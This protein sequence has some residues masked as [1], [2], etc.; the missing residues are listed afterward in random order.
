MDPLAYEDNSTTQVLADIDLFAERFSSE[1]ANSILYYHPEFPKLKYALQNLK[2]SY[3]FDAS[4]DKIE[5]WSAAYAAGLI[6]TPANQAGLLSQDPFFNGL[7]SAYLTTMLSYMNLDYRNGSFWKY[8]YLSIACLN[9]NN[10][11]CASTAPSNTYGVGANLITGRCEADKNYMWQ[12]F[13]ALYVALKDRFVNEHMANMVSGSVYSSL[14]NNNYLR[15]FGYSEEYYNQAGFMANIANTV[16]NSAGNNPGAEQGHMQQQYIEN[17]DSYI[18]FWKQ[19][20]EKCDV[21]NLHPQKEAILTDITARLKQICIEGSDENHLDGSSTVRPSSTYTPTSFEEVIRQ[22]MAFYQIP[23]SELCHPYL[24]SHPR[25]YDLQP[26]TGVDIVIDKKDECLCTKI[27]LLTLM[28]ALDPN[29]SNLNVPLSSKISFYLANKFSQTVDAALL[30]NL[31]N[32]CNGV[33]ANCETNDPPLEIPAFLSDCKPLIKKCVS[34]AEYLALK[35]RFTDNN[36]FFNGVVFNT[37]PLSEQQIRKNEAFEAFMNQA[38]GFN[39]KWQ[40]YIQFENSCI[41]GI[42]PW[43]YNGLMQVIKTFDST[44]NGSLSGAACQYAFAQVFNGRFT[45]MFNYAQIYQIYK[46]NGYTLEICNPVVTASDIKMLAKEFYAYYGANYWQN[47]NW[48]NDFAVHFNGHYSSSY[49]FADI[50]SIIKVLCGEAFSVCGQYSYPHL[51]KLDSLYKVANNGQAWLNAN[52][53]QNFT[54]YFN[55]QTQ[56]QLT[57]QDIIKKYSDQT[58]QLNVCL[59]PVECLF[60]E[61]LIDNYRNLGSGA[62]PG[63]SQQLTPEEYCKQCFASFASQELGYT[64]TYEQLALMYKKTCAKEIFDLCKQDYTCSSLSEFYNDFV[65][66]YSDSLT[67]SNCREFFVTK[68]NEK[69]T[70]QHSFSQIAAIYILYCDKEPP[71][72]EKVEITDAQQIINVKKKFLE[73]YPDPAGFFGNACAARFTDFF[74]QQFYSK[75]TYTEIENYYLALTGQYPE[76]CVINNAA[77]LLDFKV[78]YLEEY[79]GYNMPEAL[80]KDL[81]T[82]LYNIKFSTKENYTWYN[83]TDIYTMAGIPLNIFSTDHTVSITCD[84]LLSIKM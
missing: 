48:Q 76:V 67:G 29:Y 41:N 10:A 47:A 71:L 54:N 27:R 56:G 1:W 69:Y 60:L 66:D 31:I 79:G 11:S 21:I 35:R 13:K 73:M 4:L 12:V 82:K 74:N 2:P 3:E 5:T 9:N 77:E 33:P 57:W 38:T 84:K 19:E 14:K 36:P 32:G 68:F 7:G 81:F 39:K 53:E 50:S 52:C 18:N 63:I 20:L 17:C 72:C 42:V 6:P 70:T 80:T 46:D 28:V 58:M 83:V 75:Y 22:R 43:D 62:C 23:V 16:M 49:S 40:Q 25:P 44:Y 37:D 45:T 64:Y 15:R 51:F 55:V 65:K 78:K 26:T 61:K 8:A 34:C 59:P 24:I 30:G